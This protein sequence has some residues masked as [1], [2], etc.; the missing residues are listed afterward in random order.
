M[1][2]TEPYIANTFIFVRFLSCGSL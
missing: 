1:K 2:S